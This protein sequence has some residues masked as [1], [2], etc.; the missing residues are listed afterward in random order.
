MASIKI[1]QV[2]PKIADHIY[3]HDLL[4][5]ESSTAIYSRI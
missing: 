5:S 1:K 2:N 3:A 4:G